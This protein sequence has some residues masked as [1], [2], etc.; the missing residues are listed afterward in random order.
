MVKIAIASG[1]GGTGKTTIATSLA[2]SLQNA[3]LLDADVEEP[4]CAL[5]LNIQ[6]EPEKTATISFP[7]I[8][9]DKCT[10]CGVCSSN[11]EFNALASVK[12]K[13]LVFEKICHGCGL[14]VSLCEFDAISEEN[15]EIGTIY[16]SVES[17]L[18]FH[19]GELNIGEELS[20]IVI[21]DLKDCASDEQLKIIIDAPPGSGCPVV[22]TIF[23]V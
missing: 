2:L 16:K 20:S 22:E 3:H 5:F 23:D 9:E 6:T 7:V 17:N 13:I 4:N 12:D 14:C 21:G 15:R 10:H 1:K 18:L 8:D 11:C 19:Y